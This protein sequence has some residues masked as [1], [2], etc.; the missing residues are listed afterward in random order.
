V[1][2]HI[3]SAER[4]GDRHHARKSAPE[5]TPFFVPVRVTDAPA[6]AGNSLV[7]VV[8]RNGRVVRCES[9]VAPS[10]LAAMAAA[11]EKDGAP[12]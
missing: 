9:G 10:V 4:Q 5:Q 12:C 8:L 7:E 1:R 6:C 2:G 3:G 11:L